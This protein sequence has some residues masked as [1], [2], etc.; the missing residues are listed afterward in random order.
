MAYATINTPEE[1]PAD[2]SEAFELVIG[3][4]KECVRKF[5][6]QYPGS[7]SDYMG[8]ANLQFVKTHKQYKTGIRPGGA[9][10]DISFNKALWFDMWYNLLATKRLQAQRAERVGIHSEC[11]IASNADTQHYASI[12]E[13]SSDNKSTFN[14]S[15]F[16]EEL[17]NDGQ[18][19]LSLIMDTP[20][21]LSDIIDSKGGEL[22]NIRS[23]TKAWLKSKNK[24]GRA[25]IRD[26][27]AELSAVLV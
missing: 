16:A 17:S 19:L 24:W 14:L 2:A 9:P 21:E 8:D 1:L 11:D 20:Q 7:I 3:L 18:T 10:Y 4:V 27:F 5:Y 6:M 23:S 15:E 22:R 26:T 13:T 25:R 12:L